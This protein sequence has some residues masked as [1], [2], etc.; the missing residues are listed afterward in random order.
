MWIGKYLIWSLSGH[1][2]SPDSSTLPSSH[3]HPSLSSQQQL[4][5]CQSELNR[6]VKKSSIVIQE[7]VPFNDTSE[8]YATFHWPRSCLLG[9][10]LTERVRDYL[11]LS[12]MNCSWYIFCCSVCSNEHNLV[13]TSLMMVYLWACLPI[14][15]HGTHTYMY[16]VLTTNEIET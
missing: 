5:K 14:L 9:R 16:A 10:K 13:E 2:P 6:H 15:R 1:S 11:D 12:N 8:Y 3:N 7:K 4:R